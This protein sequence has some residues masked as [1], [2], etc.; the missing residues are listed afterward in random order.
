M[1]VGMGEREFT[2]DWDSEASLVFFEST[3]NQQAMPIFMDFWE[4]RLELPTGTSLLIFG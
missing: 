1:E 2:F 4:K 3:G